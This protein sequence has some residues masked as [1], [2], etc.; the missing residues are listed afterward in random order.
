MPQVHM[1]GVRYTVRHAAL[2]SALQTY[3]GIGTV[4]ARRIAE[5]VAV[6]SRVSVRVD[7]P[8]QAYDLA[9]ELASLGVNAEPDESDY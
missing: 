9:S 4:E 6:G 3:T 1:A 2:T 7:D 8:E 5:A